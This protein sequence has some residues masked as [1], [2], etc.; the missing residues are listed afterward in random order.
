MNKIMLRLFA[1][2]QW[3]SV[4]W[5]KARVRVISGFFG[6]TAFL[7]LSACASTPVPP[8]QAL[9]AAELAIANADQARVADYASLELRSAREK[10]TAARAAVQEENMVQAKRL[11]EQAQVDAE[12]AIVKTDAIKAQRVN[13]ELQKSIDAMK[14][15]M[16]RNTGAQ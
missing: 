9:Q 12:L 15:E 14:Q 10:L 7:L 5:V 16:Q 13:E 11:A 4:T 8:N 6:I 1:H 2:I 3:L